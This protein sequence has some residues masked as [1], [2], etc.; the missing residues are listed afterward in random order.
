[1]M[2]REF[3]ALV[4]AAAA[5]PPLA[6][7]AQP[8]IPVIGF[9]HS[10]SP[11]AMVSRLSSFHQGLK[12]AGYVEG[13]NVSIIY[14]WAQNRMEE[15]PALAADLIRRQVAL[16]WGD[17]A[18]YGSFSLWDGSGT[19]PALFPSAA[20][21]MLNPVR[22][23]LGSAGTSCSAKVKCLWLTCPLAVFVTAGVPVRAGRCEEAAATA[24]SL[25]LAA[26]AMSSWNECDRAQFFGCSRRAFDGAVSTEYDR[27][28]TDLDQ[29][30][31]PSKK[32]WR[33][34]AL[35]NVG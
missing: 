22:R 32:Q 27:A 35:R 34:S 20:A 31:Q 3:M 24:L 6:L 23:S 17:A 13:E 5:A 19:D 28:P 30:V 15:L 26:H 8:G 11:N 2:R 21:T 14:R 18:S 12:E 7:R 10:R 25:W 1:M 4:G 9:L 16:V 33:V 29:A